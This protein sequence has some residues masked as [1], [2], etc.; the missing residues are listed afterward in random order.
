MTLYDETPP[1]LH[2]DQLSFET[3]DVGTGQSVDDVPVGKRAVIYLRVS[4]PSQVN[5]DYDPEGISLPAQRRACYRKADQLGI[6]IIDEYIEPG[7]SA[8]EMTKRLAF[9]QMLERIRTERDVDYVII[10]KLSRM[11]RNRFDDAI[12]GA[13]LKK[14][15][16]TLISA[17]ESIDETPVGQL[18]H[19]ILAAFNEFRSAEEGA[20]IAYK[21]GEK[22]KKGGTLGKA[23]IGYINTIDRID[24]REIRAVAID[25]ERAPLVRLA[26]E[27]YAAGEATLEDIQNELT[28][29][30]LR[31]RPTQRRPAGPISV[32]KIHQMLQDPYYI[33]IVTYKGEEYPGRHEP[34]ID[35]EL[36]DQV[37]DLLASRGRAGE[38]R[39]VVHHYL[40]GTLWCGA[41]W[42]RDKSI[43]RMIVRRTISRS[44]EEYLYFFCRGTQDGFC[45]AKYSNVHRIER[46]VEE[47]YRTVQFSPDFLQAMRQTL[48]D[49]LA[50]QE[51]SQRALKEQLEGQL[52][53]LDAQE[54]NLL[55]LAVDDTIPKE[56]IR[57]KLR[58]IGTER[59]RLTAQLQA[60]V[61]T[62]KDA[63]E[64]IEANLRLLEDPYELY[65]NASDEVR[66]RLNQAVFKHIFIDHDE[67][68]DHDLEDPLGD[69]FTV[70]TI[71]HASTIGAPPGRLHDLAQASWAK[72][73]QTKKKGAAHMGD[74]LTSLTLEAPPNPAH[75]VGVCSKPHLVGLAGFEPTTP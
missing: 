12:V 68:I 11:A 52:E 61:D 65:M 36:F 1:I 27:M 6:T 37:Q 67:I 16:V 9:Q 8:R 72:H 66:R 60:T 46:A 40:K 64:F 18:M 50:E 71:Y 62:L 34:L 47:H 21:M 14:R 23:P 56:K 20:D 24:G 17:T 38:R 31:T 73:Y 55:E 58:E 26:F 41:C 53:R 4:T 54:S 15:G 39:R 69:L 59:E 51:A 44:G 48:D 70:Q 30:G 25:E 35:R 49:A 57:A 75:R 22:A 2:P 43:R 74:S 3:I 63:V 33:G 32:S 13:E 28:D 42:R 29:R 10:Y 19:G 7:R 45:D 5:T